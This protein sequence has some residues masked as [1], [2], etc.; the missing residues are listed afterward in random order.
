MLILRFAWMFL[1]GLMVFSV[2]IVSGQNPST[3]L[4]TGYP[5]KPIRIVV[6]GAGSGADVTARLLVEG[7]H[8]TCPAII[9]APA[10][11]P[12]GQ[13]SIASTVHHTHPRFELLAYVRDPA[14]PAVAR[15]GLP[16]AT[17]RRVDEYEGRLFAFSRLAAAGGEPRNPT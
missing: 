2:G 3:E 11:R 12:D 16:P 9:T 8:E 10:D 7:S 13:Q 15:G 1:V 5:N 17:M 6:G 4:R 14:P